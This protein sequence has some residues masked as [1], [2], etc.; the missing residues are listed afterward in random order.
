MVMNQ[1]GARKCVK[2]CQSNLFN[3]NGY[4][5]EYGTH[6]LCPFHLISVLLG[7]CKTDGENQNDSACVT[8]PVTQAQRTTLQKNIAGKN[9]SHVHEKGTHIW[10]NE[11]VQ[12]Q[13]K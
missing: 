7:K 2:S 12:R 8:V 3:N 1:Q 13:V 10:F 5:C 4:V 11:N 9:S 6:Q